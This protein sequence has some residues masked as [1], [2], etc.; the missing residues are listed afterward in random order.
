MLFFTQ[1]LVT[2]GVEGTAAK[3]AGGLLTELE[4]VPFSLWLT[5]SASV[6]GSHRRL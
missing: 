6:L 4:N 3:A 2:S 1:L 5:I